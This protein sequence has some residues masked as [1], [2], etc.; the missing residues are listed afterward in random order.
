MGRIIIDS[1]EQ[2]PLLFRMESKVDC[3]SV[4]DYGIIFE[5]GYRYP[6]NFERKGKGDLFSTLSQ[7]Y[8]RFKKC[9]ERAKEQDVKL[10]I[11]IEGTKERILKGHSHSMRNGISIV[12]QLE[13]IK[14]RYGVDH[15]FFK[16]RIAMAKYIEEFY[17]S[18]EREYC[19]RKKSEQIKGIP[20]E[21][22][23]PAT[24]Q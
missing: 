1:R 2:R 20:Q 9:I 22:K 7:G 5:D 18:K 15:I 19:D 14:E 21:I 4:G 23:T 3:L 11:V 6:L 24:G 12:L 13:T 8:S 10:V 16:S 17:T